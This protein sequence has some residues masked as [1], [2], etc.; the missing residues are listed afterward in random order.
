MNP[1][2]SSFKKYAFRLIIQR[3]VKSIFAVPYVAG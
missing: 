1:K 2:T 3:K